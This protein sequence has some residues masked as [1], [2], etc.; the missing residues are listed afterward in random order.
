MGEKHVHVQWIMRGDSCK[1]VIKNRGFLRPAIYYQ[2]YS[3]MYILLILL[4]SCCHIFVGGGAN[5][6][7]DAD[8]GSMPPKLIRKKN[9]KVFYYYP[10]HP[11]S[12]R[13]TKK[14]PS[15]LKSST[16]FSSN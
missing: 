14:Q 6:Y 11:L 8:G 2:V 9:S 15:P 12:H 4:L 16:Y 10:I 5:S 7:F 13:K 3:Y 1:A